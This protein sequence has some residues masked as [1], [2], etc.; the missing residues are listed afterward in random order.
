MASRMILVLHLLHFWVASTYASII[1]CGQCERNTNAELEC[2][3]SIDPQRFKVSV[4]DHKDYPQSVLHL[5][6]RYDAP[7]INISLIEDCEF[8]SVK[9]V[10]FQ[11]CPLFNTSFSEIFE[12]IG[13]R[14]ENVTS[15]LFSNVGQR[16]GLE[17]EEWHLRGL[18]NLKNLVF[19]ANSF[20]AIPPNLLEATP[21][22]RHFSFTS[23][24]MESLPE[25]LFKS[26]PNLTEIYLYNNA[27]TSLPVGL[28]ANLSK[29]T[30]LSLWEN[31][32]TELHP[33]LLSTVPQLLSLELTHNK[34]SQFDSGVFSNLTN[35]RSVLLNSNS[36][37]FLPENIFH[38]CPNL[39]ILESNFN[40]ITSLSSELF[41]KSTK[42]KRL[43]F[44]N[45]QIR[46]LPQNIFKGLNDLAKLLLKRNGL[47]SLPVDIFTDLTNLEAL[48]LQ[49]NLLVAL[50]SRCFDNLRQ[51]NVLV[52]KNNSISEL[53]DDIFKN[54]ESLKKLY[55]SYNNLSVLQ[56]SSF[57][58]PRTS[59]ELLDL[60]NNNISFSVQSNMDSASQLI[61]LEEH[62]PLSEQ[63][64]LT[65]LC[66]SNNRI[67]VVSQAFTTNFPELEELDLDG[68]I[69]EYLD[70]NYLSFKSDN[71]VIKLNNNKIKSISLQDAAHTQPPKIVNVQL[72]GNQLSC[73]C[74]IYKFARLL[75]GKSF[76]KGENTFQYQV[77]N[78]EKI[79]CS[80]PENQNLQIP[81]MK[82]NTD[83]LT[84]QVQ[85][86]P[87]RC[88]CFTRPHDMMLIIN[89]AYQGLQSIPKLTHDLVKGNYS[90][91][92][93][94]SN[95]TITNLNG[96]QDSEYSSLVNLTVPNNKLS[97]I[98][99]S[100]LPD[101]LKVL[102]IRG[103]NFTSLSKSLLEFLNSSVTLS[104][105]ENPWH[106]N[107]DLDDLHTFLRD[108]NRK[109]TDSH[110]IICDNLDEPLINVQKED[111][112]PIIRQAMVIVTITCITIFLF[113]FC[114]LG[115]VS[116]YKYKQDVKVWLFTHRICLWAVVEEEHEAN[117]KYDA[118]ISYS[119]KDEEFVNSV[120]VPGLESGDPKYK[121]CLHYR[122]WVPGEYI[123]D[124]IDQSIEASRRTIVIL[125]S[126]SVENVWGQL[127]F[128]TAH[129][130]A[131]K[132]KTNKI[133]VI[134]FGEVPPDSE[135][136]EELRL[137]L[138][139][140]T[141]LQWRD[142][143]FWEKLRYVMPHPQEFINKHKHTDKFELVISN[144]KQNP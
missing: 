15:L 3:R 59:L 62:F 123:Q 29:L 71:V 17:L 7:A 25:S 120:L 46:S 60:A 64:N 35:L 79:T 119:N 26:T 19:E 124:Q 99:E 109:V 111:L 114:V 128:K 78:R 58:H 139:T 93:N 51:M 142:P 136:D 76:Q 137:Y 66:L 45:N 116:V 132:E 118:F 141:Y 81:V 44:S 53:P 24:K 138:S 16:S 5:T 21:K 4:T 63:T 87:N 100:V 23:N 52:L 28:F 105:G 134:V 115:T 1:S 106:C 41:K 31:K 18:K 6:C 92:L 131:L 103:N 113:L 55:V 33:E 82:V 75:Q 49:S 135:L 38:N 54:C 70:F 110:N 143:K 13:I 127:Q 144:S 32:L 9:Y 73:D 14:P 104:L 43:D 56:S 74:N 117:K 72:E 89:C 65:L 40:K 91:T 69:I 121:V 95:N 107:C 125:S 96:L 84:C 83:V 34:I 50:P 68:N 42:L 77:E 57:P 2:P 36:L 140:R 22:L 8:S 90:L 133:I 12:Q 98:N 101:H 102:D 20:T 48:D 88:R 129:S 39:E 97:F 11:R 61:T 85:E 37:E 94:L 30:N 47:T 126:N 86:C 122:D 112:C 108:P 27:F 80:Y 10:E 130:K 67:P